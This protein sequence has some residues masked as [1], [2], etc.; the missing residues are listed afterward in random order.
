MDWSGVISGIAGGAASAMT[1]GVLGRRAGGSGH[2]KGLSRAQRR[3]VN[4]AVRQGR[5]TSGPALRAAAAAQAR[6]RQR[7]VA[8]TVGA[9]WYRRLRLVAVCLWAAGLVEGVVR[10]QPA[11]AVLAALL[12][13]GTAWQPS[14]Q[15]RRDRLDAAAVTANERA[16]P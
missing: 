14:L 10:N 12:L 9:R 1:V 11:L 15:R 4:R 6:R 13:V 16:G 7:F 2:L 8:L 5:A 3:E